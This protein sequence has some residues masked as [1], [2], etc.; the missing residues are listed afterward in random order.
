MSLSNIKTAG[1]RGRN[2]DSPIFDRWDFS[3]GALW[4]RDRKPKKATPYS[5]SSVCQFDG[6]APAGPGTGW[7]NGCEWGAWSF[8]PAKNSSVR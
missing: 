1:R 6:T 5:W 3:D 8:G 7:S 4:R 2:C